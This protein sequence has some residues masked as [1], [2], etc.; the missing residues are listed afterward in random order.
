M[1]RPQR[2]AKTRRDLP[3]VHPSMFHWLTWRDWQGAHSL[4]ED[5]EEAIAALFIEW[6]R[7]PQTWAQI[8]PDALRAW[9]AKLPGTRPKSWWFWSAPELR[10]VIG[11]YT[12][13]SGVGR[14]HESGIPYLL[15]NKQNPPL[16]ETEAGLLDRL[17]LWL[18]RERARV[19]ADAFQPQLFSYS[20]TVSASAHL[21][22]EQ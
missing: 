18:P 14:C 7:H 17:G 5:D 8:E 9:V 22:D 20:L 16:V 10:Q 1:P 6:P 13:I 15:H 3:P 2:H 19:N 11:E 12:P 21:H 4:A